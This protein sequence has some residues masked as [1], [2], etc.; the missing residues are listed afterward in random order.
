MCILLHIMKTISIRELHNKTGDWVRSVKR[1]KQVIVTDRGEAIAVLQPLEALELKM[2]NWKTRPILPQF[3]KQLEKRPR[4]T[5]KT[6]SQILSN[7]RD[8]WR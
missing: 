7:E 8:A 2:Y 1:E 6:T 4:K 3:Q 5:L